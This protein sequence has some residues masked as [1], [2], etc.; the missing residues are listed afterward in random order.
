ML[1][2]LAG[3]AD[4]FSQLATDPSLQLETSASDTLGLN[5]AP[6]LP[7]SDDDAVEVD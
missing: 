3:S 4:L 6:R 7:G 2:Q 5:C 1:L